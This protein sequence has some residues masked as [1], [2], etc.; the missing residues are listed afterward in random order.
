VEV[1]LQEPE[2]RTVQAAK[3]GDM[4]AFE[5]LV[6]MFQPYVW[7]LSV[8][9]IGDEQGA[10]DVTQNTFI[11]IFRS[12]KRF[13]GDSKFSTWLITIARNCAHDELR[14]RARRDRIR[15]ASIQEHQVG[16]S[17]DHRVTVEVRDALRRLPVDLREPIVL[18]DMLGFSYREAADTLNTPEGT[19]KS[20]VHRARAALIVMLGEPQEVLR[21][22]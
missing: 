21:E 8:H 9:L 7:R 2:P 6:R 15:R 17:P 18:I 3:R 16:R 4:E 10:S 20:R 1:T 11:K 19:I 12:L 5:N 13:K 14:S 22:N